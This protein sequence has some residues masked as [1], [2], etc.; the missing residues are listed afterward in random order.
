MF[1]R[2]RCIV[3]SPSDLIAAYLFTV[4]HYV[5]YSAGWQARKFYLTVVFLIALIWEA[6]RLIRNH[7]FPRI[8]L[9]TIS[10]ITLLLGISI[11]LTTAFSDYAYMNDDRY[12]P[13]EGTV[14]WCVYLAMFLLFRR[15]Y[16]PKKIHFL[17]FLVS[18]WIECILVIINTCFYDLF[19]LNS[20]VY[21]NYNLLGMGMSLM[22]ALN[23]LLIVEEKNVKICIFHYILAFFYSIG[24]I[25][26]RSE[27]ALLCLAALV[28]ILPF[29][30]IITSDLLKK[31]LRLAALILFAMAAVNLLSRFPTYRQEIRNSCVLLRLSLR[32]YPALTFAFGLVFFGLQ[33]LIPENSPFPDLTKF[34]RGCVIVFLLVIVISFL[35]VNLFGISFGVLDEMLRI[36]DSW[37][38][39][40]G[41]VWRVCILTFRNYTTPL[42]K[43]FG[44]GIN[45]TPYFTW[46]YYPDL[47]GIMNQRYCTPHNFIIQWLMEGGFFGLT[48][49]VL[50]CILP[51]KECFTRSGSFIRLSLV[52]VTVILAGSLVTVPSPDITPYFIVFLAI[53]ASSVKAENEAECSLHPECFE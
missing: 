48:L 26:S 44:I 20:S 39:L 17:L 27:N 30:K 22:Y 23:L 28:G 19:G 24:L 46:D 45:S 3:S 41:L 6:I 14:I 18:G 13:E 9:D 2:V 43:L 36:D 31:M 50:F 47:I 51:L 7:R 16:V 38:S 8:S 4:Y 34:F 12:Y 32:L 53:C 11:V 5:R 37:G 1:S 49:F 35:I 21:G 40:R 52:M 42:Q 10:I 33:M 15:E 25:F 29:V